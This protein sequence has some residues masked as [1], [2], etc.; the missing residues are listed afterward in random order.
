MCGDGFGIEVPLAPLLN[1]QFCYV[2]SDEYMSITLE[3]FLDEAKRKVEVTATS[4]HGATQLRQYLY[5]G[6]VAVYSVRR[7]A[8]LANLK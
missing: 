4:Y 2:A 7:K 8:S 5:H 6:C 3:T 1:H